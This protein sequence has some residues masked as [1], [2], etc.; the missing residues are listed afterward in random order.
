MCNAKSPYKTSTARTNSS[1]MARRTQAAIF[2]FS[3]GYSNE[4][5]WYW[6][7]GAF[8]QFFFPKFDRYF[9]RLSASSPAIFSDFDMSK[10]SKITKSALWIILR[11]TV[12]PASSRLPVS[13]VKYSR[14]KYRGFNRSPTAVYVYRLCSILL[15]PVTYTYHISYKLSY[16]IY[17][18]YYILNIIYDI[19]HITY[20]I[21][22]IVKITLHFCVQGT[23]VD[24]QRE[25]GA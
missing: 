12:H 7:D 19:L 9:Y 17:H 13:E 14:R 21:S 18:I 11:W 22:P 2:I 24:E 8:P 3:R 20:Y 4:S 25:D 5:C 15:V 23:R 10:K 1:V 16:I 6:Q